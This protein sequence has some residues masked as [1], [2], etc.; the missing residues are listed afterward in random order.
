MDKAVGLA[1]SLLSEREADIAS[2]TLVPGGGGT[3]DV[4]VDGNLVYSKHT[5]GRFPDPGEVEKAL[6]D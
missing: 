3:F 6:P 2:L 1:T 4:K 5:T